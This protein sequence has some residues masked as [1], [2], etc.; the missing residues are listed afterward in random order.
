MTRRLLA[1]LIALIGTAAVVV[2]V[3]ATFF[4]EEDRA[5]IGVTEKVR[6]VEVD[7]ES[8]RVDIVAGATD[9]VSVVRTRRYLREAPA[10]EERVAEGVLGIRATCTSPVAFGCEVD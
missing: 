4:P 1:T 5:T 2:F 9:A 6:R 7:V 10:T 8:G 3:L